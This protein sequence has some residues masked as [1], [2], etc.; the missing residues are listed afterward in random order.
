M[1]YRH[2]FGKYLNRVKNFIRPAVVTRPASV[3]ELMDDLRGNDIVTQFNDL[4][5]KNHHP[6]LWRGRKVLKNPCDLW[7]MFELIASLRPKLIIETGTAEGGSAILYRDIARLL[8]I[9]T[10]IITIDINPKWLDNPED[11]EI[12]SLVGLSTDSRIISHVAD[13]VSE[14]SGG[15]HI[16]VCLDSDHS[17]ENV[18]AELTAYTPF[19]TP[20]SYCIVEDTNVNG[21]PSFLSHGAGP[22]E[23]VEDF[24]INNKNFVIDDSLEKYLLTFNP[25]GYLKKLAG[26]L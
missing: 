12:I 1:H 4:Y 6:L 18:L 21:H 16:L 20:G 8:K 17:K 22:W 19:V 9:D 5:Y 14:I 3:S 2:S 11:S 25:S 26:T 24:L 23:A 7:V 10:K 15:G 13:Y